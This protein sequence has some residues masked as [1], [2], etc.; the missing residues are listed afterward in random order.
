MDT[1]TARPGKMI[2]LSENLRNCTAYQH[3][4][5]QSEVHFIKTD[6]GQRIP[7]V[8]LRRSS[9]G[10]APFV[11][12]HC[13]GNATDIGMMMGPYKELS[14]HLGVDVVGVEYSG[15]G[16]S[17]GS[18]SSGNT[19]ADAKAAYDH[20]IASGVPAERIVAYGQSV[21]CGPALEL[22]SKQPMGGVVLH[23]PM[24]SGIKVIDP[25]PDHCCRPSCVYRCFDFFQNDKRVKTISCPA[26]IIHGQQDNIIPFYHG[27]KLSRAAPKPYQWPGYF[28][29]AAGHNDIV[30]L[31]AATYFEKVRA[32]IQCV[33]ERA[34]TSM[35]TP[36][37]KPA[38]ISMADT[39]KESSKDPWSEHA[40]LSFSE[41]AVGPEDGRYETLRRGHGGSAGGA[42]EVRVT[43]SH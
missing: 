28:P 34:S 43:P 32:F 3:A 20:L 27:D 26:F 24:L 36:S 2:Y 38:Q 25:Q 14:R 8:W 22:A 37:S 7:I 41:P 16:L 6:K 5:E 17:T 33:I 23:S 15:Y 29:K 42:R 13:H 21:G 18:P 11:L 39:P 12:L 1:A 31:D 9:S 30:E 10:P 35:G 19:L 4:A 40:A